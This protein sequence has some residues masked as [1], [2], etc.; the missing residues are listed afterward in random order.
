MRRKVYGSPRIWADLVVD[1]GE[2]I[3]RKR[4]ERLM[5]QAGLSGLIP[6]KYK[7]TT[8]RVPGVRVADDLLDRDFTATA[9]NQRW[10][11]DITYLRTWEG[12]LYL[13]AVQD[14]YSRRIV[15]W[16]MADHMR[17]E[18]VSDALQMAL[19]R[20]RPDPGLIWHS[21][22]GSQFVSLAFGQQARA[23][24]I[25]Q[26]MGSK[27]DC[28]DNAVAESFFATLKKE[29]IHRRA[30][31]TRAELRTEVFDYIEVFYNRERRHS[32]LGQRSPVDYEN[33]TLSPSGSA[34]AASRLA[35]LDQIDF[36]TSSSATQVA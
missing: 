29:L 7:A 26:S 9:A 23:A 6:K 14:L 25:A 33:S 11:A 17:T 31:P 3:G 16:S 12:W 32:T 27:G 5:R 4:V 36:T 28:F 2:R 18:L 8:V 1:D 20:R 22:Q 15:G 21:D 24:G 10:V 30:W 35:S 13:V 19:A 34:L